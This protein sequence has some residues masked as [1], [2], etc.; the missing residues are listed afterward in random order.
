VGPLLLRGGHWRE[1]GIL[2]SEPRGAQHCP[3]ASISCLAVRT[4]VGGGPSRRVGGNK[5]YS[6]KPR[7]S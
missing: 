7:L 3:G 5:D 4:P 6:L 2:G 1:G